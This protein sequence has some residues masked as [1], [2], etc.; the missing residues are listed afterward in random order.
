M[1]SKSMVRS[2]VRKTPFGIDIHFTV[3]LLIQDELH[4]SI[5]VIIF[6]YPLQNENLLISNYNN[7]MVTKSP[8]N[9]TLL[10]QLLVTDNAPD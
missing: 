2:R 8:N 4:E 1:S 9:A 5:S 10:M 7:T 3:W 6:V